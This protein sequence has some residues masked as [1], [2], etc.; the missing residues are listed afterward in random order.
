MFDVMAGIKPRKH[1][2]KI[3]D[4]PKTDSVLLSSYFGKNHKTNVSWWMVPS[5]TIKN[6]RALCPPHSYNICISV[7]LLSYFGKNHENTEAK[8][9]TCQKLTIPAHLRII[10]I[11]FLILKRWTIWNLVL[12]KNMNI[13]NAYKCDTLSNFM[14]KKSVKI[15]VKWVLYFPITE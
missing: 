11:I 7:L 8:Y 13:C 3:S 6:D 15:H 5:N 14:K 12:F 2:I 1:R 4:L 10:I 9:L